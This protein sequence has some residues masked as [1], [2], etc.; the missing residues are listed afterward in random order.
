MITP[1]FQ[2]QQGN[3]VKVIHIT[4]QVETKLAAWFGR[5]KESDFED[6]VFL[7]RSYP[8]EIVKWSRSLDR[9]QRETFYQV[10]GA[11]AENEEASREVKK[12]LFLNSQD[13]SGIPVQ[14]SGEPI[15]RHCVRKTSFGF[16][17]FSLSSLVRTSDC[18]I[19]RLLFRPVRV[20]PPLAHFHQMPSLSYF[21]P[22]P[23]QHR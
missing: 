11:A 4:W 21:S 12:T 14:G 3:R 8:D 20:N 6:I 10:Y 13:I 15:T 16:V 9:N 1:S 19:S 7:L 17:Q 2:T 23:I 5:R 22:W 18:H